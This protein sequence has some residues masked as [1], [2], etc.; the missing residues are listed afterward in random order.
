MAFSLGGEGLVSW[1]GGVEADVSACPSF[2]LQPGCVF[3]QVAGAAADGDLWQ[4]ELV[5][6]CHRRF[7]VL[8]L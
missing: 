4:A 7:L 5:V 6:T 3:P 8:G 1:V 2:L